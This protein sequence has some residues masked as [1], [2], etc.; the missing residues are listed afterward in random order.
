MRIQSRLRRLEGESHRGGGRCPVCRGR[1][2]EV[3]VATCT[4]LIPANGREKLPLQ[5]PEAPGDPTPCRACG[6]QPVVV[7]VGE[8]VVG[9]L[10]VGRGR[11]LDDT[12]A[13]NLALQCCQKPI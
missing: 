4:I 10:F 2:G 1:P 11:A 9:N 12:L 7:E 6:W 5:P 8:V 13:A 3:E